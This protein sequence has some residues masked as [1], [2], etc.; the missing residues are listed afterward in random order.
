MSPMIFSNATV[1]TGR[2]TSFAVTQLLVVSRSL[3]RPKRLDFGNIVW[4]GYF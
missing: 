1:Y 3:A 4:V 2:A